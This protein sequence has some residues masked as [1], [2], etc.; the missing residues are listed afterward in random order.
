MF[1]FEL[2]NP[3]GP[4]PLVS[5]LKWRELLKKGLYPAVASFCVRLL[6]VAIGMLVCISMTSG[7]FLGTFSLLRILIKLAALTDLSFITNRASDF[8]VIVKGAVLAF[9]GAVMH[10]ASST[11]PEYHTKGIYFNCQK[12]FIKGVKIRELLP[13]IPAKSK[14]GAK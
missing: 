3:E 12:V 14:N 11:K 7:S 13:N 2:G 10:P 1:L 8:M 5:V 6:I 4:C 9:D